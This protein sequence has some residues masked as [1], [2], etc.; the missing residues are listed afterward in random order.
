MALFLTI[1]TKLTLIPN[2]TTSDFNS[3]F[4]VSLL[5]VL[6]YLL[7]GVLELISRYLQ[8]NSHST[9]N[10][11][12]DERLSISILPF[13]ETKTSKSTIK[14]YVIFVTCSMF[15]NLLFTCSIILNKEVEFYEYFRVSVIIYDLAFSILVLRYR[16][17]RHQILS[18]ITMIGGLIMIYF[19]ID[20]ES[21]ESIII[22]ILVYSVYAFFDT[23]VKILTNDRRHSL[24]MIIFLIGAISSAIYLIILSFTWKIPCAN[25]DWLPCDGTFENIMVTVP[26]YFQ[27]LQNT[28]YLVGILVSH[29]IY[30]FCL[31][32]TL[33]Y[34]TPLHR[35]MSD[36][37]SVF[38][39]WIIQKITTDFK[40]EWIP[41]V[42]Y[43]IIVFSSMI[44]NEILILNFWSL[45]FY[46]KRE[47]SNR[48]VKEKEIVQIEVIN[49]EENILNE[50]FE[51]D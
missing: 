46:T 27:N 11:I 42:G 23:E 25:V 6:V 40:D 2:I 34:F 10:N 35:C 39:L 7:G 1:R 17:Y 26:K 43:I 20:V 44:Y 14:Y 18:I 5:Y 15:I 51:N 33:F 8:S 32:K 16:I 36:S 21:F 31:F 12:P 41:L 47:I 19:G 4:F 9:K 48:S 24:F 22:C 13:F 50:T 45:N 29:A 38:I 28:W 37:I 3:P 30:T 49:L